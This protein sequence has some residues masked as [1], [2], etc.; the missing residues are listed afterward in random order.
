MAGPLVS[1]A[2]TLIGRL[3]GD[4]IKSAWSAVATEVEIFYTPAKIRSLSKKLA[5]LETVKTI[6]NPD[7]PCKI[8]SF[9]VAPRFEEDGHGTFVAGSISD[10]GKSEHPLI[11]G[12][13]GQGKSIFMRQL[14]IQEIR[15][16]QRLPVLIELRKITAQKSLRDFGIE[17]LNM[18]GFSRSDEIWKYLL[19]TGFGVLLLDGYDEVS[20]ECRMQLNHEISALA[21]AYNQLRMVVSSR[22]ESSIKGVSCLKTVRMC[23]LNDSDRNKLIAKA[24]T[25]ST[26]KSLIGKMK[27]NQNLS[28]IVDTPLFVTLLCIVYGAESR[29][30]ENVHEFYDLVFQTLLYRHDDQKEGYIRPRRSGLGNYMF[31]A[32]F[33]NFCFRSALKRQLRF[34]QEEATAIIA[35]SLKLEGLDATIGDRYFNDV[36]KIT[37]LLVKDGAE[38]Q[39]LHKSIQEY[40]AARY[41]KRLPDQKAMEFYRKIIDLP[42]KISLLED[43]LHYLYEI[44][45]YRVTKYFALPAL[46]KAFYVSEESLDALPDFKWTGD[47][48]LQLLSDA[49]AVII[50][51]TKANLF[52]ASFLEMKTG[53]EQT[54]LR[55][56][57]ARHFGMLELI[58]RFTLDLVDAKLLDGY[59]PRDLVDSD[60]DG[61]TERERDIYDNKG[62]MKISCGKL[63]KKL[64][65]QS[66]I[67]SKVN[68]TRRMRDFHEEMTVLI[69]KMKRVDSSDMLDFV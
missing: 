62:M 58:S 8:S 16:G 11:E 15:R 37:C 2:T 49:S 18:I 3:T 54:P 35:H 19:E 50:A 4:L 40:F 6:K 38:Y 64:C 59:N 34:P 30:P 55:V 47:L 45:S 36:V 21:M 23:R 60:L 5:A 63:V 66:D 7:R 51:R 20:E 25:D 69:E 41:V 53:N 43:S 61:F 56:M 28:M 1:A 22:P 14:C 26:A 46:S 17:Y 39:F 33:E 52:R 31:S 29:L 48:I 44:D 68:E 65:I 9:Y 67:A 27:S 32:V 42:Q 24:C 13:A 10:F 57:L 12:I